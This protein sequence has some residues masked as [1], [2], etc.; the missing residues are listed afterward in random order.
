MN[1]IATLTEK[2]GVP[3]EPAEALAGTLLG[4]VQDAVRGDDDA[5]ANELGQAIPE[6]EGWK[7]KAASLV[8]GDKAESG[9]LGGLLGSV[10][11]AL[12]GG[13]SGGLLGGALGALAGGGAE[14]AGVVAILG[15]LGIDEGKATLVAPIVLG[16]L[17]DRLPEGLLDK[18]LA[19]APLLAAVKGGDDGDDSP[20]LASALGGLGGLGGLLGR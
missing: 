20:G 7:A 17:K 19:V 2:L 16:F 18:V 8:E 6:L 4:G 5:A 11:P 3:S 15:K 12:G 13:S 10:A 1:L 9:G 14:I